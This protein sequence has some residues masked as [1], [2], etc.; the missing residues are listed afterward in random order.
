MDI[1]DLI[2]AFREELSRFNAQDYPLSFQ[3][4]EE[5]AVSFFDALKEPEREAGEL[6]E[7]L[8]QRCAALSR[9]DQKETLR[10][11]KMLL[12]L[13]L[14]PTAERRGEIASDYVRQVNRI[15]NARFPRNTFRISSYDAIMQGFEASILGIPLKNYERR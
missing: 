9:R 12:S 4:F 14:A 2:E 13:Y 11:D 7:G 8:V 6:V 5:S 10:Q 1:F 15:W 3:R